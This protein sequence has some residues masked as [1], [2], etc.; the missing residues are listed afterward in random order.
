MWY[1]CF[2]APPLWG[3]VNRT[4]F[5]SYTSPLTQKC[6]V[7]RATGSGAPPVALLTLHFWVCSHRVERVP[8]RLSPD[9]SDPGLNPARVLPSISHSLLSISLYNKAYKCKN[10]YTKKST[11]SN[12]A[13]FIKYAISPFLEK[14]GK[15][16]F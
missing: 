12:S 10:K 4:I 5:I 11:C 9:R 1:Y 6:N 13:Y 16:G 2:V 3:F 7:K 8:Y 14:E 15:Q